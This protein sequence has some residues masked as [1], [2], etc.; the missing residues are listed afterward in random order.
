MS[1]FGSLSLIPEVY[2]QKGAVEDPA[3]SIRGPA[4]ID[5]RHIRVRFSPKRQVLHGPSPL[6]VTIEDP[7]GVPDDA[8]IVMTYNG[9]DVTSSFL[10]QAKVQASDPGRH[11][12]KWRTSNFRLPSNIDHDIKVSYQRTST[13]TPIITKYLPP[14]CSAFDT[15]GLLFGVPDFRP[16]FEII[17]QINQSSMD[18]N[19]NPFFVAA[20][21]AQESG[22][23]PR[24]VSRS[25]AI[26]LTQVTPLGEEEITKRYNHWPRYPGASQMPFPIL[27]L[28]V[29]GGQIHRGNEWRLDP[30][31]SIQGG[32]AYINYLSN[33][34]QRP[35]KRSLIE[36]KLGPG[37]N[38]LSEVIL[39]SYNA[40]ATRVG[41]S[42]SRNGRKYLTDESLSEANKYVR[43]V[44]SY[45]DHF[46]NQGE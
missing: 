28:A 32:V 12:V 26:G 4:S 19:L 46:E 22:F 1:P 8:K 45:C 27:K 16:P 5:G 23:D 44:V 18:Q 13:T 40:G 25:R 21:V 24:A 31:L 15:K 37:D 41:E 17:Q 35:E 33:Y 9:V 6:T 38:S 42:L 39:A 29:V 2:P 11:E 36:R 14:S 43:R 20:L 30:V 10:A 3:D 34:W 7:L